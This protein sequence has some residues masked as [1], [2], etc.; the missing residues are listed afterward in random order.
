MCLNA[1]SYILI[2]EL[3]DDVQ[4]VKLV[5]AAVLRALLKSLKLLLLSDVDAAADNII[6]VI[7]LQPGNDAGGIQT[8]GICQNDFFFLHCFDLTFIRMIDL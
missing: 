4:N 3:I 7:L 5:C 6:I 2:A 1:G 8:A